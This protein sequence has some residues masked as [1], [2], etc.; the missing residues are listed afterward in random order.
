MSGRVLGKRS[1][2]AV[3]AGTQ[4]FSIPVSSRAERVLVSLETPAG[5]VQALDVPLRRC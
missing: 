5:E 2:V 3:H 1:D 4:H